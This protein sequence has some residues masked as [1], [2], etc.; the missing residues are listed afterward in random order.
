MAGAGPPGPRLGRPGA[1]PTE[2]ERL[3]V[4][5]EMTVELQKCGSVYSWFAL[6][7]WRLRFATSN[8]LVNVRVSTQVEFIKKC[9]DVEL[10]PKP[11][12]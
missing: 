9:I 12:P 3:E 5:N 7:F 2:D 10:I 6:Q 4:V 8:L 11:R 1:V